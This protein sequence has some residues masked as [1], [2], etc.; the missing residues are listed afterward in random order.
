MMTR[1]WWTLSLMT[2]VFLS[3]Q[4]LAD[5]LVL[6]EVGCEPLTVVGGQGDVASKT[7]SPPSLLFFHRDNW[8]TD[9]LVAS[10]ENY[11]RY[12]VRLN[13]EDS[14]GYLVR[15]FLKYADETADEAY[16]DVPTLTSGEPLEIDAFP[17]LGHQPYQVNV[18]I[19]EFKS[20]GK[21]YDLSVY[22][23]DPMSNEVPLTPA[24][25]AETEQLII[26]VLP[27]V[28]SNDEEEPAPDL[29]FE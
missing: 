12:L 15:V 14:G 7:V 28:P 13:P 19:G 18:F 29:F 6:N 16:S 26:D 25:P 1:C 21:K 23:C 11:G 22:G 5:D 8:N 27:Q 4:V 3:P 2:F 20:I 17:R 9:F 10:S 24:I